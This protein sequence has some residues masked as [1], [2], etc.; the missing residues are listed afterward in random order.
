MADQEKS[1]SGEENPEPGLLNRLRAAARVIL[2]IGAGTSLGLL[3]YAG[4]TN[5]HVWLTVL[6][7]V[8][9]LAPFA[10]LI[11]AAKFANRWPVQSRALL[12]WVML[13]VTLASVAVY[14]ND[15]IHPRSSQRAFVFVVT[16]VGAWV[17][18]AIGFLIAAVMSRRKNF[19]TKNTIL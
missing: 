1:L 12:Y 2:F 19:K 4:R 13:I 16:P 10:A 15:A 11:G 14:A 17:L 6:F 5:Q 7:V 18:A 3:L 9:V 8:W